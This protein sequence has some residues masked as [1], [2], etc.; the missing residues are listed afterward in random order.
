VNISSKSLN[1]IEEMSLEQKVSQLFIVGYYGLEP[2]CDLYQ[3]VQDGLGGL[4]FFR[5]NFDSPE[6]AYQLISNFKKQAKTGLFIS[7]D[8]EGGMVERIKGLTQV[9]SA[10]A[11]AGNDDEQLLI[12]ANSILAEELALLGFN[13]NYTPVLD[14]NVVPA[15]P[16]IGIR[17]FGDNEQVVANA[18]MH[19]ISTMRQHGIIPV[20]KHFPG[21]GAATLD[22]HLTL[23][24]ID[25]SLE[26]LD[27]IHLYPFKK[28]IEQ[29]VEMMM[30][31][32]VYFNQLSSSGMPASLSHEIVTDLLIKKLGYHGLII[33][34][35]LNMSAISD[36]TTIEEAPIL[37]LTAGVDLLLYRNNKDARVAYDSIIT[38]IRKG[39]IHESRIELSLKKILRL[40]ESYNI[41]KPINNASEPVKHFYRIKAN[42][43]KVQTLFDKTITLIKQPEFIPQDLDR[44]STLILSI[45]KSRFVHFKSEIEISLKDIFTS[46]HE[47]KIPVNPDEIDR[48]SILNQLDSYTKIIMISYNAYFNEKQAALL[49]EILNI[50]ECYVLAAGSPYD[51]MLFQRAILLAASCG[52]SNAAL[53]AFAK[54]LEGTI[55]PESQLPL[56]LPL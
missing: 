56:K 36:V 33:T 17:S 30:V 41:V 26:E 54:I 13:L 24:V 32:H 51:I 55:K 1:L 9:P 48:Q 44:N 53:I 43:Q 49:Q 4:I 25:I 31:A 40:K 18:G 47:L 5:E 8:Q 2:S 6:M 52:Y 21:H 50:K 20:A 29:N 39:R 27:R 35:D 34:D 15:N 38:A 3:W 22:S 14:V 16:I 37:A 11:L 10:M 46:C 42:T 7:V 23:P 28:A 19:V 45:D 12:Q